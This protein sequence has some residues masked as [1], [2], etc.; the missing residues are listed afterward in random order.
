MIK[1]FYFGLIPQDMQDDGFTGFE[2]GG[3]VWEFQIELDLKNGYM[4]IKDAVGRMIPVDKDAYMNMQDALAVACSVQ[5]K[6]DQ[7]QNDIDEFNELV[8]DAGFFSVSTEESE[9]VFANGKATP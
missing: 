4:R 8:K 5:E 2:F 7:F 1:H 9:I 3:K 6:Y